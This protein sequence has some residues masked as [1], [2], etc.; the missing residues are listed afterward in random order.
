MSGIR[1]VTRSH[2]KQMSE[3]SEDVN[4]QSQ[5]EQDCANISAASSTEIPAPMKR[6]SDT[7]A[8]SKKK[9]KNKD[10]GVSEGVPENIFEMFRQLQLQIKE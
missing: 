7:T 9:A 5:N 1:P 2:S 10:M 4:A 3:M 8:E 6:G